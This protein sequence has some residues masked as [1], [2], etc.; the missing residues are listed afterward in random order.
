MSSVYF[1][2]SQQS[3]PVRYATL[4]GDVARIALSQYHC[5]WSL[6][7]PMFG[8]VLRNAVPSSG[9]TY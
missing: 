5:M 6:A 7:R 8:L 3:N 2:Y 9:P 1:W 4:V